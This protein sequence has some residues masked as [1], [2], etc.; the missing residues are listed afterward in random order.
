MVHNLFAAIFAIFCVAQ[1]C[2]CQSI[3]NFSAY[4]LPFLVCIKKIDKSIA[5]LY[6]YTSLG[7]E[8]GSCIE[9]NFK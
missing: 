2:Y 8:H 1:I 5:S 9:L 6:E 4:L 7:F 3:T